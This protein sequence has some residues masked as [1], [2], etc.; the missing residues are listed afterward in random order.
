MK[1]IKISEATPAQID[2]LVTVCEGHKPHKDAL[3]GGVL[4]EGWWVFGYCYDP[5]LAMSLSEFCYSRSWGKGGPIIER[6]GID[7]NYSNHEGTSG[8]VWDAAC[9]VNKVFGGPTPLIAAMRCYVA[10]KMG[11]TAEV[12]DEIA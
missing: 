9:E 1:T 8:E 4:Y 2:Y 11:D 6:E 10:S 5:N 3:C 7:L 12:P